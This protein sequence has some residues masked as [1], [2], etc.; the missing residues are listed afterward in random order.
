MSQTLD[1]KR[2]AFVWQQLSTLKQRS[3]AIFDAYTK[4]SKGAGT[5]I[6]QN[7]LMPTLAFYGEKS[8][9]AA[10]LANGE[11]HELLLGHLLAWVRQT[12]L[13]PTTV[14]TF[15]S[16][17]AALVTKT[18]PEYRAITEECLALIRWIRHF[19]SALNKTE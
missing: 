18:S 10:S 11:E 7:G 8:G 12:Q 16:A 5:L 4:L 13:L 15:Q 2:A 14:T 6:M 17:M 9:G 19:A 3:P 1:Q